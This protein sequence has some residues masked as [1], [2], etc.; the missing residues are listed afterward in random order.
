MKFEYLIQPSR[1]GT[2]ELE[3]RIIMASHSTGLTGESGEVSDAQIAYFA[4]KA[5]GGTGLIITEICQAATAIDPLRVT[6]NP[7]RADDTHFVPKLTQLVDA[8]HK[9][10]SKAAVQ[11]TAGGGAQA[12]GKPWKPD[13]QPQ[14]VTP[15]GVLALG[16]HEHAMKPRILKIPEIKNIVEL[17]GVSAS[18]AKKA[19]FDMIEI[20]AHGGYLIAQFLSPY[21]NK[22]TDEYGGGLDNRCRFL[23]EIVDS[24][25]NSVGHD[26]AL[27]VKWSI[28][29]FLPGGWDIGQSQALA[30][31]LEAAGV[32]GLGVSSGVHFGKLPSVPPYFY[33]EG[34]FL[35]FAEAIKK[36]VSIPVYTPGRLDDPQLAEKALKEG[37]TD[38]VSI[39]RGLIADPDW[40]QKVAGGQIKEIRPCLACNECRHNVGTRQIPLR[41]SVNAVAGRE[42]ELDL[43]APAKAKRKV[44]IVGS[45]PAGLEAARVAAL[46]GHG[47][48]LCEKYGQLGGLMLL[49]G[50]HNE[51]VTAFVNWLINQIRKLPIEVRLNTEVTL[52][53]VEEIQPDVI[54]LA[55]GG[56][57]VSP[58][59]PGIDR[60]NVFS[61]SDLLKILRGIP[62]KKGIL[63]R[64][65]S[66][67]IKRFI[68]PSMVN[69]FLAFNYPIKKRVVVI[70]GQFPGCSLALL[71][72]HKGKRVTVIEESDQYGV[73]MELNIMVALNAE[74]QKG[75]V[76]VLTTTTMDKITSEGVVVTDKKRNKTVINTGTVIVALDLAP[77]DSNLAE[78]LKDRAE[79]VYTIGDAKSFQRIRNAVS[80]GY[81]TACNL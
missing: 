16:T 44:M 32:D 35:H 63:L 49:A 74:V 13:T 43:V 42:D 60:N 17:F 5:K 10:G 52:A 70:G 15:S 23:M 59:V 71:L 28:E 58:E 46:R 77:S 12:R 38:F 26:F 50:V 80:E 69:R 11:M 21:F 1:I 61:A 66:P 22:R 75:N 4:R 65:F 45:G 51:R 36:V 39:A 37:K 29:D 73:D 25:K 53:L 8:V 76:Q 7:L 48:I 33:P 34:A 57:F 62:I 18:N 78:K 72:A 54:V 56:N 68:T 9:N 27:T 30:Q 19:G 14:A 67:I 55:P 64:A 41:C 3:N 20:H 2:L 31:K 6:P 79:D 24:V 40:I 47:A 81:V